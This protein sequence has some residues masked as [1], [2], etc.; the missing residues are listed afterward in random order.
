MSVRFVD[1]RKENLKELE[2]CDML[3]EGR[4]VGRAFYFHGRPPFYPKWIEVIYDPWPRKEGKEQELFETLAKELGPGGRLFV[5]YV[6]DRETFE[7][8]SK[9]FHP[10]ETPL[11]FALLQAGFTW[12]K[13][14]YYPEG[15]AEGG[16][17]LQA[18]L[19]LGEEDAARQLCN[20]LVE[21]R[22]ERAKGVIRE[23]LRQL[24]KGTNACE[25]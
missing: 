18:N 19:P 22:D 17:K 11:G 25:G 3:F 8:L 1:C 24:S 4:T 21:V 15:G 23:R 16:M 5:V 13:D 14:W 9:G 10:V 20:L 2:V 6:K 12:F 7:R